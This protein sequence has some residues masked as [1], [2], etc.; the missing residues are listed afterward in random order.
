MRRRI[1]LA[2]WIALAMLIAGCG[3]SITVNNKT[4]I[5][6]RVIVNAAGRSEVLSPSPGESSTADVEP[7]AYRVTVIRDEEWIAYAKLTRQYLNDQ[8]ANSDKLTGPQ[9]LEVIRR[10]KDIAM[11]MQQFEQAA[12]AGASCR[13]S[14]REDGGGVAEISL[15]AEGKLVVAC[16]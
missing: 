12:G 14:V 13:G 1:S 11:Q 3:P 2:V 16:K 4:R 7:G 8:L 6:V 9:L 10:L 5:P 15:M